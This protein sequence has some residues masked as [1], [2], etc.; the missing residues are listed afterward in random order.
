MLVDEESWILPDLIK[1]GLMVQCK[2][3]LQSMDSRQVFCLPYSQFSSNHRKWRK[4]VVSFIGFDLKS[5]VL[6]SKKDNLVFYSLFL[7][8]LIHWALTNS[9]FDLSR[10][11]NILEYIETKVL[12]PLIILYLFIKINHQ[13][14]ALS[15]NHSFSHFLFFS[16]LL[17][18]SKP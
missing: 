15:I 16:Y 9:L 12:L 10:V 6:F 8:P 3:D 17:S 13:K 1:N 4:W 2:A 14:S 5:F 11:M 7:H 18:H